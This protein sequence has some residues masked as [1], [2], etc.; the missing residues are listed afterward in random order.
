VKTILLEFDFSDKDIADIIVNSTPPSGVTVSKSASLI[1]AS[2]NI[3]EGGGVFIPIAI[4]FAQGI[5]DLMIGVLAAWLYDRFKESNKKSC[6]INYQQ[7]VF[8]KRNIRCLI[9]KELKNQG[10]RKTQRRRDKN[11]ANK[12]RP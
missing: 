2:A 9:K 1:K 5:R 4:Q 3:G 10:R 11:R 7:V 8:N 12:K 6:R